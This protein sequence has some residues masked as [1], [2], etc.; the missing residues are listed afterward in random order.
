MSKAFSTIDNLK[1]SVLDCTKNLFE[2]IT[3]KIISEH[4]K[5]QF[6]LI[7][8]DYLTLMRSRNKFQ[9]RNL[10]VEYMAN[11]L[12]LLAKKLN[13]CIIVLSQLNREKENNG[14]KNKKP[15]LSR[16]YYYRSRPVRHWMGQDLGAG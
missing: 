6:K 9:N 14:T 15:D 12:K 4:Q 1:M 8:I 13:T 11:S 7:V 2:E 16:R 5:E 10:E 3:A